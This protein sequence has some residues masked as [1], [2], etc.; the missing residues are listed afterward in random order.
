MNE[1]PLTNLEACA[2]EAGTSRET[3][4]EQRHSLSRI[5]FSNK[6]HVRKLHNDKKSIHLEGMT[7]TNVCTQCRSTK[8]YKENFNGLRR[9]NLNQHN[10]SRKLKPHF[11]QWIDYSYSSLIRN[12]ISN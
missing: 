9:R 5:I 3:P 11:Y 4:W 2:G 1:D 8:V 12:T 7:F 6:R 10:D